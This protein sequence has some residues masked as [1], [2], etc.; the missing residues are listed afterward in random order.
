[1]RYIVR[2]LRFENGE[3]DKSVINESGYGNWKVVAVLNSH[4]ASG[5][6]FGVWYLMCL[7]EDRT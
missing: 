4:N 3:W 6:D 5:G 7:I 1:M 2:S